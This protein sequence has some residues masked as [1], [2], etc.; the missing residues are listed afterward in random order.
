LTQPPPRPDVERTGGTLGG[1][2][3]GIASI[4]VFFFGPVLGPIAI[5]LGRRARRGKT[6]GDLGWNSGTAAVVLGTIGLVVGLASWI[7]ASACDCM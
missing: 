5:S 7:A 4:I 2:V 1:V 3:V 6:R